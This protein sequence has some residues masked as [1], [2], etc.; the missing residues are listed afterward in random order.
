MVDENGNRH[1]YR[2]FTVN[3]AKSRAKR[4]PTQVNIMIPNRAKHRQR[5]KGGGHTFRFRRWTG[6]HKFPIATSLRSTLHTRWLFIRPHDL[7]DVI[8]WMALMKLWWPKSIWVQHGWIMLYGY[9][10][11]YGCGAGSC[12]GFGLVIYEWCSSHQ[13][14]WKTAVTADI[15]MSS[16]LS[17]RDAQD[18]K[19]QEQFRLTLNLCFKF[20]HWPHNRQWL[21]SERRFIH[22]FW[23]PHDLAWIGVI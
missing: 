15:H 12:M 11:I 16:I 4:F 23:N 2:V 17:V 22:G 14:R 5:T 20:I 3:H 19:K 8:R 10:F 7:H 13:P 1:S 21:L 9:M 6:I 18:L